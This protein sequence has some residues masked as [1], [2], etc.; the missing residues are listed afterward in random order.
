MQWVRLV[1]H[2]HEKRLPISD[3][4]YL[5]LCEAGT[6]PYQAPFLKLYPLSEK[7]NPVAMPTTHHKES[8]P[9]ADSMRSTH[10]A[11]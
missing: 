11:Q 7:F 10:P 5:I 3:Y 4:A 9:A 8:C 6:V 1:R 2:L